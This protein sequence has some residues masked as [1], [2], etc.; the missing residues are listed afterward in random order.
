MD[1]EQVSTLCSPQFHFSSCL[2]DLDFFETLLCF[3]SLMD[4][5]IQEMIA[6]YILS[7]LTCFLSSFLPQQREVKAD[8][9]TQ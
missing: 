8:S 7:S 2:H 4:C 9:V 1:E 3:P 6:K 5:D